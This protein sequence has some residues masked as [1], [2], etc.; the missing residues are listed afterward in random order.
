MFCKY[1][2]IV[3][4]IEKEVDETFEEYNMRC[5]FVIKNASKSI[6][7]DSLVGYSH[8]YKNMELLGCEYAPKV[9]E[10]V[11]ELTASLFITQPVPSDRGSRST[12]ESRSAKQG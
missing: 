2:D 9:D 1:N 12:F 8:V 11:K 4:F 6:D 10:K 3:T 5:F 7:F